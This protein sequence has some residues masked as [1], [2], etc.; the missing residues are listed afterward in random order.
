MVYPI[1]ISYIPNSVVFR[2]N[3]LTAE[4]L[5]VLTKEIL[6]SAAAPK[7]CRII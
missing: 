7:N 5:D 4:L 3:D 2:Q 6:N 1:K